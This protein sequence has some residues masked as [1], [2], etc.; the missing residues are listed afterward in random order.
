MES[1]SGLVARVRLL[2]MEPDTPFEEKAD[3]TT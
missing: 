2:F 1:G 3:E